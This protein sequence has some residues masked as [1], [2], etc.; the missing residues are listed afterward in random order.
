[1][2]RHCWRSHSSPCRWP[3]SSRRRAAGSSARHLMTFAARAGPRRR[4]VSRSTRSIAR[5]IPAPTSTSSPAAAGSRRIRC[6][7]IADRAGASP[8]CRIGTSR[9]CAAS[10]RRRRGGR[11]Q[12]GRRLLRGVHG[13]VE[14]RGRRPDA[15]RARSRHHRRD[16]EPRRSAGAHR[17][18][19]RLR[20]PGRSSGSAR[21][22]IS[23]MRPTRSRTSTRAASACP[24]ATTT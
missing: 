7:P 10:S 24:T 8:R 22:P 21:K 1:M 20:H 5:S 6:R 15:D 14:D 16:P 4:P 13:R 9:C 17:P 2:R 23:R 18:P 11:P 19:A 12:E 3:C